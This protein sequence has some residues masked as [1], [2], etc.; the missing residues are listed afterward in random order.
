VVERVASLLQVTDMHLQQD[1][2][3][4][5]R[6]QLVEER[7]QRVMSDIQA[8]TADL[9]L[10]TGDLTHHAPAAYKRLSDRLRL[11]PF[12]SYW[13][14][15][16]HDLIDE[17]A[18]YSLYGFNRKLIE[19][20][21][22]RIILLDSSSEPDGQGSGALANDELIFLEQALKET[23][24]DQ[25]VLIALHHHPVKV[26]SVW[27]DRIGLKNSQAFWHVVDRFPQVRGVMFGHV[28]QSFQT[29]RGHVMLFSSPATAPQFKPQCVESKIELDPRYSGPAYARYGLY[30]DGDIHADVVRLPA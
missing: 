13:I 9:L 27:Q 23:S 10:L 17:M 2:S 15:G 6:E 4:L 1:P 24:P 26:G 8:E 25:Y 16:N 14:P 22:W 30:S 3:T 29:S 28:H 18:A 7:F 20:D 11:L 19:K 21:Q 12:P 5:M